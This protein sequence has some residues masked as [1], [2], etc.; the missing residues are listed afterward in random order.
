MSEKDEKEYY[1]ERGPSGLFLAILG[2]AFLAS[3]ASLVWIYTLQG[4]LGTAETKLVVAQQENGRLA[5][6]LAATNARLKATSET[7]GDS[8]GMT[9]KQLEAKAQDILHRQ[10]VETSRLE[11]QQK[12]TQQQIGSVSQQVSSVQSDVGGVK[13][14]VATTK[15]DLADTKNQLQRVMGD[16]GVMSGLIATN[17]AELE[18]LKHKGD[19]N[20][21]EFTLHRN[22]KPTLLSTISLQLKKADTKH[23]RYTL[24]VNADDKK[25]E[26]KDRSLDE[27]VQFYTGKDPM[28]YEL[29]VNQIN[30][31]QVIGYLSTPKSAPQPTTTP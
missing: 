7:L 30:K 26:K 17:H 1:G 22:A 28:L 24:I 21:Y 4:R 2:I 12:A 3:I 25:I 13:T 18:V 20:Y 16:A 11:R 6:E 31:N 19:R 15:S 5:D 9:Q 8:V 29:V 14:D 10:Q 23:Q 27:P